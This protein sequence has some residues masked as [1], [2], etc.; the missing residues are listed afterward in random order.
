[1]HVG[2]RGSF[3][4]GGTYCF[5]ILP[6]IFLPPR[7]LKFLCLFP[8][9]TYVSNWLALTLKLLFE[10]APDPLLGDLYA[11]ERALD[12]DGIALGLAHG[13]AVLDEGGDE[14]GA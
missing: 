10:E 7:M 3:L 1:M 8:E 4:G 13:A 9:P 14:V 6:G 12:L 2:I 5:S 11:R